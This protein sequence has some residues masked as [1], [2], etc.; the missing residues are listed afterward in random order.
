MENVENIY[1]KEHFL[2]VNEKEPPELKSIKVTNETHSRLGK[3]GNV[4]QS[5]ED[6]IKSLL[7]E[8]DRIE[9]SK[10]KSKK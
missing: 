5:F 1:L 6:V 7:D 4:S 9:E 10:V 3:L 8:H 2:N